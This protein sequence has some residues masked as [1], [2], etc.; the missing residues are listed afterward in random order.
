LPMQIKRGEMYYADLNP[1]VGSEQGG[2]RPVLVV[3]NELGNLHSPTV[4]VAAITGQPKRFYLPTHY[5]LPLGNGLEMP[6]QAMLEQIRTIDKSRLRE[7]VGYLDEET[8]KGIDRALAVSMGLDLMNQQTKEDDDTMLLTLCKQCHQD[9]CDLQEH[10]I[11]RA[12]PYQPYKETCTR[13]TVRLGWDY[14]LKNKPTKRG[15]G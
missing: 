1:V 3:Q 7:Y 10:I 8:M 4:V 12:N 14:V 13:C 15:N 9:F 6:S 2:I 11:H 5:S